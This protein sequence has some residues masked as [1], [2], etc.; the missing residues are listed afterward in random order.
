[1]SRNPFFEW[2]GLDELGTRLATIE[3]KLEQV[4]SNQTAG[5]EMIMAEKEEIENLVTQ[6]RQNRDVVSSATTALQGLVAAVAQGQQELAQAIANNTDVSPDIRA[7]AD[8]LKADTDAL[9][10]AV[11]ALAEAVKENTTAAK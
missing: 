9:K 4:L 7:A 11:P 2:L 6:V 5:K 8:E 3:Q 1:M 10:A